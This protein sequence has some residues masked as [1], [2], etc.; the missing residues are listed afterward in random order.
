MPDAA[1]P[2]LTL[3]Q[4]VLSHARAWPDAC[5]LRQKRGDDWF[6]ISWAAFAERAR[7]CAAGLL[8]L[9][10][11]PPRHVAMFAE[12]R[13]EWV[14]AQI[15][16]GLIKGVA[17]GCY[18][19]SSP[20]D[21]RHA[22]GHADVQVLFCQDAGFLARIETIRGELR[23]LRHIVLMDPDADAAA[24]PD[25][26]AMARLEARGAAALREAPGLLD[27]FIAGQSIDDLS[28]MVYTSGSTG[29][30]KA[31]MLSYRNMRASA[32]GFGQRLHFGPHGVVLSYLPMCHIAEQAMSVFAPLFFRTAA[33]FGGGLP[34]L[35][36]D[37]RAVRPTYFSGVPRVWLRL[38]AEI[39]RAFEGS[40]RAGLLQAALA[41]G[42][43]TAF[44]PQAL[45]TEAERAGLEARAPVADEAKALVGLDRATVATSGAAS[46]AVDTLTFFRALD[47]PLLEL[48]GQTE[49]CSVMTLQRPDKVVPGTVGEP[50]DTVE[51]RLADDGEILVRGENVFRGYYKNPEASAA[52]MEDGW[53]RTGDVGRIEDGQLRIV[54][55]KKDI[56]I[57]D[58]G[59]NIAPAEIEALMRS[60]DL[61]QE[62]VLV[63][64]G[65]K[66]VSALVQIDP[67]A[68]PAEGEGSY[69]AVAARPRTQALVADEIRR[70]NAAL[71][72]VAQIKRAFIL[73]SPLRYD[74]GDLTPT[75][76]LRRFM[77]H[78]RHGEQIEAIYAG[79]LG[80]DVY[81]DRR[82]E[83]AAP[84]GPRI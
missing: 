10:L 44:K 58:G 78:Q 9:G 56:M 76:K 67:A 46:L 74:L 79:R 48:L 54:D 63:A 34:T 22:L 41:A 47:L 24:R 59:K 61:I 2:E 29:A 11:E 6:D 83:V 18:P 52:A 13:S 5:A 80:F 8:Q 42:A 49:S 26:T 32:Q 25:V 7:N 81:P 17:L 37:L 3:P 68:F 45:W 1:L 64:E 28:L 66:Y 55:R 84:A 14:I 20:E 82:G 73:P 53:L 77:V 72:R 51:L 12:N 16:T 69:E 70:L 40:G 36:E 4:L 30:P 50:I 35:V 65:R 33:A 57:T 75:L 60:S 39:V 31:A 21:L 15:A 19:T 71:A 27:P 62:C 43:A 38:Q 23:S